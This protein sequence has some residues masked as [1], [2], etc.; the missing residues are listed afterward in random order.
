MRG[1]LQVDNKLFEF[2]YAVEDTSG[3]SRR[4]ILDSHDT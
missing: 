4:Q 1:L 2:H 3:L